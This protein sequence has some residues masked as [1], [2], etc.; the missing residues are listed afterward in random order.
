[1]NAI[2]ILGVNGHQDT[3]KL[4]SNVS[5]ALRNLNL[6][7]G[8]EMVDDVDKLMAS[9]ITGIPALVVRRQVVAQKGIPSVAEL[10][11]LFKSIFLSKKIRPAMKN[12]LVPTDFSDTAKGAFEYAKAL[13][14]KTYSSLKV[15]N[16]HY[17]EVTSMDTHTTNI[18]S[19]G[20]DFKKERL[21]KF[22]RE[23]PNGDS[24]VLTAAKVEKEVIIGFPG[25]AIVEQSKE[26]E[27]DLI[28]M[29]TTGENGFLEKVFGSISTYVAR[30]AF[31]PV[32]LVPD[33][34][35]FKGA[36]RILYATDYHAADEAMMEHLSELMGDGF[37]D[38]HFV[39][40]NRTPNLDYKVTDLN[41]KTTNAERF[42]VVNIESAD[43]M[44][45][46]SRYAKE[47]RIDM[48]VIATS[49]RPFFED[50]FHKSLTKKMA[51]NTELP[52]LVMHFDD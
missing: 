3:Q 44:E 38:I 17:P 36:S 50:L 34:T 51:M 11:L 18:F 2:K 1:M 13:A 8:V 21:A 37:E 41:F 6:R 19:E 31:C 22:V 32:L 9:K 24:G 45:G 40:I 30:K 4:H 12:I 28:V 39:H 48:V 16:V 33:G 5:T 43:E 25:E 14:E 42:H 29:G 23:E 26:E 27:I 7:L 20:L 15:I 10:Q 47:N 35:E 49:H 46:I 52:L